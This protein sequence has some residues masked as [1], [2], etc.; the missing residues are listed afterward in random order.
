MWHCVSQS[1]W[2]AASCAEVGVDDALVVATGVE[3]VA[4]EAFVGATGVD[5][6]AFSVP[7]SDDMSCSE[8]KSTWSS[9]SA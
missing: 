6:A 4:A 3:V 5:A 1:K 7:T 9:P 2:A 8:V